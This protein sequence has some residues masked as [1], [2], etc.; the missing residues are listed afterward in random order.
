MASVVNVTGVRSEASGVAKAWDFEQ[1]N[2]ILADFAQQVEMAEKRVAKIFSLFC[3]VELNYT[4]KYPSDYNISDIQTELANAEIAK[5]LSFGES[6][7]IEV[8]KRVLTAYL[9][10]LEDED[11]DRLVK[12]YEQEEKTRKEAEMQVDVIGE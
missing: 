11:F 7:N 4:V 8:F 10:E 2:Q 5:G 12:A 1:T 9:P 6:F 3:G